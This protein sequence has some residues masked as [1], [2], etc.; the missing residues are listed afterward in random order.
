MEYR[1]YFLCTFATALF[2]ILSVDCT[3]DCSVLI[4]DL[5]GCFFLPV[6]QYVVTLQ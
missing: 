3:I 1:G 2:H 4:Y 6:S 5:S